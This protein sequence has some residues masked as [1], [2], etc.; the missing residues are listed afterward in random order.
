MPKQAT[1]KTRSIN[2]RTV[3]RVG[4]EIKRRVRVK[5]GLSPH[6]DEPPI[7]PP[8]QLLIPA[9]VNTMEEMRQEGRL[10]DRI[11]LALMLTALPVDDQDLH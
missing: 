4:F 1:R 5:L 2:Q 8:I 7:E 10:D 9:M 3:E 6:D 11:L